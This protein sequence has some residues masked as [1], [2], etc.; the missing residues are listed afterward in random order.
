[1]IRD[2]EMQDLDIRLEGFHEEIGVS[3]RGQTD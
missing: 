1:M 3:R 2:G